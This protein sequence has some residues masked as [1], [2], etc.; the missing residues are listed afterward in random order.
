MKW[1][2]VLLPLPGWDASTSQDTQ[3]EATR[4]ITT[5]PPPPPIGYQSITGLPR[6]FFTSVYFLSQEIT[7]QC[8]DCSILEP[9]TL[10]SSNQKS[11]LGS[12]ILTNKVYVLPRLYSNFLCSFPNTLYICFLILCSFLRNEIKVKSE[13]LSITFS[14]SLTVQQNIK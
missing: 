14:H 11:H 2:G 3:H 4:S 8:R 6:C 12:E 10:W 1:Q 9:W 5:P 7:W 13:S